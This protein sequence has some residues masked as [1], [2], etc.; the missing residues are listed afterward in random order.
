M[1][2]KTYLRPQNMGFGDLNP[3]NGAW[4]QRIPNTHINRR[5]VWAGHLLDAARPASARRHTCLSIASARPRPAG[6]LGT[7]PPSVVT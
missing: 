2:E 7:V 3:L 1:L 6:P 5:H 4:Q